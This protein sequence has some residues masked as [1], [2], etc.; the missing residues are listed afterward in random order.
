[1]EAREPSAAAPRF[2]NVFGRNYTLLVFEFEGMDF[3][4]SQKFRPKHMQGI[5]EI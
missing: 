4:I 2:S 1:L 5:S 3:Q